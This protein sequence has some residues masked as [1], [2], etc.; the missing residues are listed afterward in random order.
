VA[1]PPSRQSGRAVGRQS[2]IIEDT[3]FGPVMS[4]DM[5]DFSSIFK[6]GCLG[7]IDRVAII[8]DSM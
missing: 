6:A 5:I 3:L 2:S 1:Q 8:A 4:R 7:L